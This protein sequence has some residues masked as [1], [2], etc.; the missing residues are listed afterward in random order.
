MLGPVIIGGGGGG[1]PGEPGKSVEIEA[2]AGYIAWRLVG[3]A[4]WIN[5]VAIAD[6]VGEAGASVELQKSGTHIQ[7]RQ[8]GG[9]W[10]D[11]VAL[12]DITGPPGNNATISKIERVLIGTQEFAASGTW[13]KAEADVAHPGWTECEVQAVAGGQSGWKSGSSGSTGAPGGFGGAVAIVSK[14]RAAMP[15]DAAVT[16]G[17]G[18]SGA[19][20]G[21]GWS[22]NGGGSS[23][24]AGVV[25][26]PAGYTASFTTN[27]ATFAHVGLEKPASAK[28]AGTPGHSRGGVVTVPAQDSMGPGSGGGGFFSQA[29]SAS[30]GGAGGCE[31]DNL[32]AAGGMIGANGANA[33]AP[34]RFGG[35]GGGSTGA[36]VGNGGYPGGGGGGAAVTYAN[37]GNGGN[38]NLVIF[39]YRWMVTP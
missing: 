39:Y 36:N 25:R 10:A 24:M 17:A 28:S 33:P 7:W 18:G 35:G 32:R 5:I 29:S 9:A 38:G 1:G 22:V 4:V 20:P 6:L 30:P 23:A 2:V 34:G 27:T 21:A 15:A 19:M 31:E 14:S 16:I 13:S 8:T 3:D 11:L 26:A 12:A 37:A